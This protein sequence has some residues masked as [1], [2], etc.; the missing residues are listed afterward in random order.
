MQNNKV[1]VAT[2]TVV[3]T[4]A[5]GFI[6]CLWA[7]SVNTPTGKFD[8]EIGWKTMT[9]K[10]GGSLTIIAMVIVA[11]IC[12]VAMLT[13]DRS[14]GSSHQAVFVIA[15]IVLLACAVVLSRL[16][17]DMPDTMSQVLGPIVGLIAILVVIGG[18]AYATITST[19]SKKVTK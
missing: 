7:F 8:L 9:E 17:D 13:A 10:T 15:L 5:A 2:T 1:L 14:K 16:F 11:V 12:F 4:L 6:A 18:I 3:A 19:P